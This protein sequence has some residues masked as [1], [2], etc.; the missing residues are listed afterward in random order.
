MRPPKDK[1]PTE[2]DASATVPSAY[3]LQVLCQDRTWIWKNGAAYFA[4]DNRRLQA[5]T[6][7]QDSAS[8]A[9]GRWLVTKDGKMCMEAALA[10]QGHA[11]KLGRSCFS[12]RINGGNIEQRKDRDG[13]WYSFKRSPEE[14]D[15]EYRK[16]EQGDTR[17]AQFEETRKLVESKS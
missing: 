1:V 13:P 5:W 6:F 2:A 9:E 14:P 17:G 16:F 15:D 12:N 3:E 11:G 4:K 8:V 10:V 7:G